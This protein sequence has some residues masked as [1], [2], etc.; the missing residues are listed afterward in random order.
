[1]NTQMANKLGFWKRENVALNAKV[2]TLT[3]RNQRLVEQ[4]IELQREAAEYRHALNVVKRA[5]REAQSA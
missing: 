5:M 3:E 1:M 2:R 4:N